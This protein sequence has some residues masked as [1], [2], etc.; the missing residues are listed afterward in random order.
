[1]A[2][3]TKPKRLSAG[4]RIGVVNPAWWLKPERLQRAVSVFAGLGFEMV[5]GNSTTLTDNQ[6]A[7]TPEERA[8]DIMAMFADPSIDAIVCARGGYGGNRVLPLLDYEVIRANPKIFVGYSDI[9]GYLSSI[10]QRSGLISF[11]GPMLSTFGEQTI[12]YNL[13]IFR[14]VLSGERALRIPSTA[15][16]RARTLR[17]GVARG[18]LWGGNRHAHHQSPRNTGSD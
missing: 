13:D 7:G 4:A 12:R 8:A 11:H 6:Y 17:P 14:Q 2:K 5:L 10:S 3:P 18:P 1:M 9:T 16:C 15:A